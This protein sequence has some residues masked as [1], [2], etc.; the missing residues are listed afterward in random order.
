MHCEGPLNVYGDERR[1]PYNIRSMWFQFKNQQG[2]VVEIK[3]LLNKTVTVVGMG[4]NEKKLSVFTGKTIAG[5][6]IFEDLNNMYCRSKLVIKTDV[7]AL[8][9]NVNWEIFHQHRVA[10]YDDFREEFKNLAKLIGFEI[11]EVD[12]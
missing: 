2:A 9:E 1:C 6:T 5:K 11:V 12:R 10:F 8:L 3:Y 7:E 4:I